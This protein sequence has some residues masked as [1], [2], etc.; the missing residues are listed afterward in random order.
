MKIEI[1][2]LENKINSP[3]INDNIDDIKKQL[4]ENQ[5]KLNNIVEN[6]INGLIIRSKATMVEFNEKK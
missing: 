5:S 6:K 4:D 1:E 2:K 3:T